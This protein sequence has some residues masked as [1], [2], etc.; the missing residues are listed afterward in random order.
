MVVSLILHH[1]QHVNVRLLVEV[2]ARFGAEE[3]HEQQ[4][5]GVAPAQLRDK[6]VEGFAFLA[7]DV[8]EGFEWHRGWPTSAKNLLRLLSDY[9]RE[10]PV[11]ETKV[12]K[13]KLF[14]TCEKGCFSGI[15]CWA[16]AFRGRV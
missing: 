7:G 1:D 8:L 3:A 13:K 15:L 6:F 2:A 10:S 12:R 16:F 5:V 11:A 4:L 14:S 9:T